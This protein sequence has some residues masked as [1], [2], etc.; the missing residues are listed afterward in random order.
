M[1][2]QFS[3][4]SSVVLT[5]EHTEGQTTSDHVK[6]ETLL[7]CNTPE[8]QRQWTNSDGSPNLLGIK[9]TTNAFISGLAS[10]IHYAHE[11]GYIDSAVHLRYIIKELENQFILVPTVTVNEFSTPHVTRLVLPS[12][13]VAILNTHEQIVS[14][15]HY[16]IKNNVDPNPKELILSAVNSLENEVFD[17][18]KMKSGDVLFLK[19]Y[20][21]KLLV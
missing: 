6:T 18:D 17:V 19:N 9:S 5:L 7:E 10:N 4:K 2:K 14:N 21:L 13:S 1:K 20:L 12:G 8:E 3:F 11:K 15:I 16:K